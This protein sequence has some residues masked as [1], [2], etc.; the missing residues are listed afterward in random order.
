MSLCHIPELAKEL[1]EGDMIRQEMK[2]SLY[3]N[4]TCLAS[5]QLLERNL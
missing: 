3:I 1:G 2:I 4:W 5:I